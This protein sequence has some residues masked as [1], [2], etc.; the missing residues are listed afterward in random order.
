MIIKSNK[1]I[2]DGLIK[3]EFEGK[4]LKTLHAQNI[5]P[6]LEAT[7][8]ERQESIGQSRQLIGDKMERIA[9]VPTI[10]FAEHPEFIHDD[11][12]FRKWL[13]NEGAVYRTS[14]RSI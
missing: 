10:V 5:T 3:A 6:I 4:K 11:K 1:K 7:Y 14:T 13:R 2:E 12:A 9:C 8:Q